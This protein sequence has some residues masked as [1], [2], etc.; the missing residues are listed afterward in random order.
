MSVRVAVLSQRRCGA[1]AVYQLL[2]PWMSAERVG[3]QPFMWDGPL[4]EV[5]R[6]FHEAS[7]VQARSM[8]D[9]HLARGV[10]FHHRYDTDAWE[11]NAMLLDA[12][13][14][15]GYRAVLVDRVPTVEHLLSIL[16]ADK[17]GCATREDVQALR[18]KLQGGWQP[19]SIA[20][21]GVRALV[22]GHLAGRR[23]FRERLAATTVQHLACDH[24]QL[25]TR[26]IVSCVDTADRLFAFCGLAP[27]SALVDDASLLRMAM[28]G[29]FYTAGLAAHHRALLDARKMIE[30]EWRA[31]DTRP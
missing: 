18:M 20:A 23:W 4:G 25:F 15:A 12:L 10:F 28:S 8:L 14:A 31:T 11:F 9:H 17:L 1:A 22:S 19:P 26:G 5:S 27:R 13:A 29:H 16:L 30:D 3:G 7:R 24:D 2:A 6:T 21:E